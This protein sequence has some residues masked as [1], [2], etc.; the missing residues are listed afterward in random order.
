ML[1]G[2]RQ[3]SLSFLFIKSNSALGSISPLHSNH[4][5]KTCR[6]DYMTDLGL[7]S[8]P[9]R[10]LS[11]NHTLDIVNCVKVIWRYKR[12]EK[13]RQG[14]TYTVNFISNQFSEDVYQNTSCT[15][16]HNSYHQ[17]NGRTD[18]KLASHSLFFY[19]LFTIR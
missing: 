18:S 3:M 8:R 12:S 13:Q 19:L 15:K 11:I 4:D 10:S 6:N 17:P 14:C 1:K 2:I 16:K 5:G 7:S 9:A